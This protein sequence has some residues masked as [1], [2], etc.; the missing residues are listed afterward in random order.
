MEA[1]WKKGR[2]VSSGRREVITYHEYDINKPQPGDGEFGR[3]CS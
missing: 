1:G 3:N 2:R